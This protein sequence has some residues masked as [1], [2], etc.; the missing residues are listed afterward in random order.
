MGVSQKGC[1]YRNN[2]YNFLEILSHIFEENAHF[3]LVPACFHTVYDQID[4]AF[5]FRNLAGTALDLWINGIAAH[6]IERKEEIA[7]EISGFSHHRGIELAKAVKAIFTCGIDVYSVGP[8][9][10]GTDCMDERVVLSPKSHGVGDF[11][12]F[13]LAGRERCH[14]GKC[15]CKD[16]QNLFHISKVLKV[17]AWCRCIR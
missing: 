14:E 10:I 2:F 15:D 7:F 6:R 3:E 12:I 13:L 17:I 5:D 4:P 16:V 9:E 11:L 8:A 1:K